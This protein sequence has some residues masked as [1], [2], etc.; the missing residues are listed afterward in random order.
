MTLTEL[1]TADV[2]VRPA[3]PGDSQAIAEIQVQTW[4]DCYSPHLPAGALDA[5]DVTLAE[6]GWR[7]AISSPPS[8]AHR[9]L[10]ALSRNAIVG[11]LALGPA[12]DEDAGPAEGEV[13]ALTVTPAE[14]RMGHGS[15]LLAAGVQTMVDAGFTLARTWTFDADAPLHTFLSASG[16][17]PDGARRELDMGEPVGQQRWHAQLS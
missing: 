6:A 16:W 8:P 15:R 3:V 11:Y 1:T 17:E 4:Q 2:S 10:V 14:Q 13:L 9:L 12:E 5:L 7:A